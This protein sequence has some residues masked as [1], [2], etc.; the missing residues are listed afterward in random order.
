MNDPLV[1]RRSARIVRRRAF[2]LMNRPRS[3]LGLAVN[4][5]F[6]FVARWRK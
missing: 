4:L 6:P 2:A 5:V 3:I 1:T